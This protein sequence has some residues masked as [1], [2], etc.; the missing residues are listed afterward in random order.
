MPVNIGG[1]IVYVKV[2]VQVR[3]M[4][5]D[6]WAS[7]EHD[8]KYKG[9]KNVSKKMS[10]ELVKYAKLISKMDLEFAKMV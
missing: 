6:F 9:N 10:K 1:K 3:T 4:A 5:M 2:E 8:I 7:L